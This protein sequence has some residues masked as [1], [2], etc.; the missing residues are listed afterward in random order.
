MDNPLVEQIQ[1]PLSLVTALD[2]ILKIASKGSNEGYVECAKDWDALV[3]LYKLWKEF[4]PQ[5]H[6]DFIRSCDIY[7]S[8]YTF[9]KGISKEKGGAAVQH[10]LEMPE[11]LHSMIMVVFPKVKYDRKFAK[12]LI[13]RLPEF[14]ISS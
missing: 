7:R 14:K 9:N 6:K 5:E 1:V 13:D 4:Y 3:Y 2:G 10:F 12:G 11:T 8:S